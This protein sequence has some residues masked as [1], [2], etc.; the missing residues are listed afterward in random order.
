MTRTSN[1]LKAGAAAG[2]VTAGIATEGIGVVAYG[3]AFGIPVIGQILAVGT[4]AAVAVAALSSD[5]PAIN[6]V[7]QQFD[8]DAALRDRFDE[9]VDL[10]FNY[11]DQLDISF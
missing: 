5:E 7:D 2:L 10:S 1:S 11:Q 6:T 9:S 3:A 8:Y 4:I